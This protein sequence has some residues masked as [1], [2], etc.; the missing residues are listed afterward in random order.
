MGTTGLYGFKK[1][2]EYKVTYNHYGSYLEGLGQV[3]LEELKGTTVEE[4]KE[5]FEHITLVKF[6]STPT[7]EQIEECKKY[8]DLTVSNKSL[9]DWYCLLRETQGTIKP[10]LTKEITPMID[11]AMFL[12]NSSC[13][14]YYI[15]DL[16]EEVFEIRFKDNSDTNIID[17]DEG[18]FEIRPEDKSYKIKLSDLKNIEYLEETIEELKAI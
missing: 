1:N 17:L 5:T 16:D 3:L 7:E 9:T 14:Y 8:A 2:N 4:L 13:Q 6:N 11:G 18:V 10:Y 15:I 12:E